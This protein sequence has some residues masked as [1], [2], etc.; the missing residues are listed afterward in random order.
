MKTISL[1]GCGNL[2]FPLALKLIKKGYC[3]KGSTK[4][5]SKIKRF[6]NAG[7]IAYLINLDEA[8][9][10]DFGEVIKR[11]KGIKYDKSK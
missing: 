6:Q 10:L 8:I 11:K 3:I 9:S 1:L 2:G 4:T 5:P 7:I